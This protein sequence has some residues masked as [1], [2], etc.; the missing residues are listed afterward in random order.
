MTTAVA[1]TANYSSTGAGTDRESLD[2]GGSQWSFPLLMIVGRPGYRDRCQ[3][4]VVWV[5]RV[6]GN[7]FK[8]LLEIRGFKIPGVYP[9][10]ACFLFTVPQICY[11]ENRAC[12]L[13]D[14][15]AYIKSRCFKKVEANLFRKLYWSSNSNLELFVQP[16]VNRLRGGMV[17]GL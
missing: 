8:I 5:W 1:G 3:I 13:L 10:L 12:I 16:P 17:V 7:G 15:R 14:H 9:F 11:S 2:R 4:R 6:Q